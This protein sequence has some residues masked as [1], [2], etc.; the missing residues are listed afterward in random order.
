MDRLIS[1]DFDAELEYEETPAGILVPIRLVHGDRSVELRARLDT[2]ASDCSST[3]WEIPRT[4]LWAAG[5]GW[6]VSAWES[7][8]TNRNCS[9]GIIA[10]DVFRSRAESPRA[11]FL[12]LLFSMC[13]VT[14]EVRRKRRC[15]G[16]W[17]LTGDVWGRP[18]GLAT[19]PDGS[20]LVSDDGSGSLWRVSY[21]GK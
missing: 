7:C 13:L 12:D 19:A 6:I 9:S 15:S 1:L 20:L 5:V 8:T 11:S 3:A 10:A 4:H 21:T 2:G 16:T 17:Q 18:M 14:G